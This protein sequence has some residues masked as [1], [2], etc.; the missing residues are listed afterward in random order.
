MK[1]DGDGEK[2]RNP[3]DIGGGPQREIVQNV[4]E[5]G[6]A[7]GHRGIPKLKETEIESLKSYRV[8]HPKAR[9]VAKLDN[10]AC[11]R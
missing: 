1:L 6:K 11:S 7:G 3:R 9:E 10:T 4:R 5:I 2:V 8:N